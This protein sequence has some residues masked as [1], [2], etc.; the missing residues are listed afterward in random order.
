MSDGIPSITKEE[1]ERMQLIAAILRRQIEVPD[2]LPWSVRPFWPTD[3]AEDRILG[4]EPESNYIERQAYQKRRE[5][6]RDAWAW[7]AWSLAD[8]KHLETAQHFDSIKKRKA[9]NE[10]L[11]RLLLRERARDYK[12][13]RGAK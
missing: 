8:P 7:P 3:A 12:G 5:I 10:E 4:W 11:E 13:P 9:I 2:A 6:Q 1:Q